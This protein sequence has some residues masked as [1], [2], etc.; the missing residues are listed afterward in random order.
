MDGICPWTLN[1]EMGFPKSAC[2]A[3]LLDV[4]LTPAKGTSVAPPSFA[5]TYGE[6]M[7]AGRS[8]VNAASSEIMTHV[9]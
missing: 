5:L 1:H 2:R 9:G 3:S 7:N 6:C 8:A 4:H